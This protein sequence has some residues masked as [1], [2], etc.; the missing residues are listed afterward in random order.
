M[1]MSSLS[2]I[3]L[4]GPL[5]LV[6]VEGLARIEPGARPGRVLGTARLAT[7]GAVA[8]A[9]FAAILV[10]RAGPLTSPLLGVGGIGLSL[11]LDALSAVM[12]LMVSVIGAVVVAFSRNY[13]DGDARQGRFVGGLCLTLAAVMLLVLSGNLVQLVGAWIATSL[14]L[15]RLLV[16]YPERPAAVHAARKKFLTARL[17]D[18]CLILAA[19]LLIAAFGTTDIARLLERAGMVAG[20]AP[21]GAMAAALLIAVAALLKSAQFP[22]HG[23][24]L[25]VMETPTPVS[26]LLHAGIINAGGF[27]VVRLAEVMLLAPAAMHLLAVVGAFTALFAG[28]AMLTESR[29]KVALAWSTVA[30]MGFMLLQCGVGVFAI[31]AL[32]IVAHSLYKAHAFLASGS[33]VDMARAGLLP[34]PDSP[35]RP[36]R[37]ALSAVLALAIFLAVGWL[38]GVTAEA[39]PAVLGL[40]VILLIGL[41]HLMGRAL[42]GG[43][44]TALVGRGLLAAAA[45]ATAYFALHAG[46]GRLLDAVLPAAPAPGPVGMTILGAVIAAFVLAAVLQ[47]LA[48][49][50]AGASWWRAVYVHLANGLYL[51]ALFDRLAGVPRRPATQP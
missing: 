4:L 6:A 39:Q 33:V 8:A 3:P 16:F 22:A 23:W 28:A 38:F 30:Q 34:L 5:A 43:S 17:G 35:P 25:E 20:D 31:A 45:T 51:N 47:W 36:A 9:G 29:V 40:G 2:L 50:L 19:G 44:A 14:A 1:A 48:P 13:L 10:W 41:A 46:A 12:F 27:L 37:V 49:W 11:R 24:L 42:A 7:L 18:G 32:H 15:H 21:V 26:A